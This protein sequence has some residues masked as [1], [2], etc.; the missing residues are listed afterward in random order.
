VPTSKRLREALPRDADKLLRLARPAV[1]LW[2]QRPSPELPTSASRLGGMPH[3]PKRWRWPM[4]DTEPMLFLGQINCADLKG[5]PAADAFPSSGLLAFFGDFDSVMGSLGTGR[6]IVVQHWADIDRLVPGTP[7]DEPAMVFPL[8]ALA[9]RPLIDLP[10]PGSTALQAVLADEKAIWRYV[11]VYNAV[12]FH[13]IPDE[14]QSHCG[15]GKLGGWPTLVQDYDV[16]LLTEERTDWRLLLQLD[17]YSNGEAL[18]EWGPG[19]SLYFLI[20]DRDLRK[21]RFDRCEFDMQYT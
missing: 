20:S 19:G 6:G 4:A 11:A 21:R 5:A 8:C 16:D 2:P 17:P 3:V 18:E 9:L 15:L 7:P 10:D 1:G 12:R 13:G 14:L